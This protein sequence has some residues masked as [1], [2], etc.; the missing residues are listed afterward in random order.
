MPKVLRCLFV[1]LITLGLNTSVYGARS[2]TLG[3]A[4]IILKFDNIEFSEDVWE[5][6]DIENSYYVAI[7][8]YGHV[9]HNLYF[10]G[11]LGYTESTGNVSG[12]DTELTFVPFG[13]NL[14][15]VLA[16]SQVLQLDCGVGVSYIFIDGKVAPGTIT[17]DA[18]KDFLWG[19]QGF[20]SINF[21]FKRFFIGADATY[22]VTEDIAKDVNLN[23]YRIGGHIGIT[24]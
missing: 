5:E 23:N 6:N 1:V 7:Q 4:N 15:Y 17:G 9:A 13:A 24:F 8:W 10:G 19:A 11:E 21:V 22:Q 20:M 18:D 3:I 12:V 14:K 2:E 16:I